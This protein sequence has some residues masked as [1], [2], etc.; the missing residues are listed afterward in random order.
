MKVTVPRD[1]GILFD[2]DGTLVD[3]HVVVERQWSWWAREHSIDPARVLAVVHG[4]PSIQTMRMFLP[5]TTTAES[6][7]FD[8][9]EAA[10]TSGVH[11]IP[12]ALD[13]IDSCIEQGIRWG[14]VTSGTLEMA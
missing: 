14:I 2:L 11:T 12:G 3:S 1:G 8:R 10:D 4:R 7:A 5:D 6:S 9:Q 13:A